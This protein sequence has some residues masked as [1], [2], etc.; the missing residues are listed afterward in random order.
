VPLW[1]LFPA[2]FPTDYVVLLLQRGRFRTKR[3]LGEL[4]A[5]YA[6]LCIESD[7]SIVA[8]LMCC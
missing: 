4:A 8:P 6:A 7:A 1:G 3:S 5:G 2:R